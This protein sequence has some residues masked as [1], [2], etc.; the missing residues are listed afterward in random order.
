M[1][2]HKKQRSW[3]SRA[4]PQLAFL[5]V[6]AI[7]ATQSAPALASSW[8]PTLIANTEASQVIDDTDSTANVVLKFG[9]T[10]AKT[11]TY[12]RTK[13]R[14]QFSAGLSV[15]GTLTGS[16]LNVDR[17]ATVG[18]TLTATGNILTRNNLSGA[19]FAGANLVDCDNPTNSK[20][21]WDITTQKFSCGT[22]NATGAGLS[23][24]AGDARY[25]NQSGDTMT[26]ALTINVTGGAPM[27]FGLKIINALSGAFLH[28]EQGLT[29]S[30]TLTVVGNITSRGTISGAT[31]RASNITQSGGILYSSGNLLKATAKG[32]SGQLLLSRGTGTPEWKTPSGSIVWYLDSTIAAGTNQGAIYTLP[33]GITAS[34]GSLRIKGAPTGSS[35]IVDI[36]KDGTSIF[37]TKPTILAGNTIGGKQMVMSTTNLT[38]GSELMVSVDQVGSTFAG[39]GLTIMLNGTRKY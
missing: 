3:H 8:N 14:F 30:G 22:D 4:S 13:A 9:D 11:L 18:G 39:S 33:F 7:M 6:V 25:V 24:A 16:T 32:L 10:L 2:A 26:G 28:A 23:Q 27:T 31:L 21:L 37:S 15:L 19:T 12:D 1:P 17:N 36:R 20:L 5:L 35:L 34:T 29:S 38:A